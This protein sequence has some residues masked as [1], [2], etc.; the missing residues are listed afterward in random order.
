[1]KPN[2]GGPAFPSMGTMES[3]RVDAPNYTVRGPGGMTLRDYFAGQALAG[4]LA[5]Q[6]ADSVWKA[7]NANILA[8]RCYTFADAML[9]QRQILH[10]IDAA[11]ARKV[12]EDSPE[13]DAEEAR[14]RA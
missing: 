8:K 6:T 11:D 3:D 7:S 9:E 1:M 12:A 4:E 13:D 5:S 2:D 14:R 10:E